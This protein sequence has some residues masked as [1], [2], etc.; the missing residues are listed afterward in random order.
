[1]H[2][3]VEIAKKKCLQLTCNL[4]LS[5]AL[6]VDQY[7]L[8]MVHPLY[9]HKML[10]EVEILKFLTNLTRIPSKL[11]IWKLPNVSLLAAL[12]YSYTHNFTFS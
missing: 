2:G 7:I 3:K 8:D 5:E 6:K 9:Q 11:K 12:N 4:Q 10:F 1:M